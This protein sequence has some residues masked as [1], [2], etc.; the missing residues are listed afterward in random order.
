MT[1]KEIQF[2]ELKELKDELIGYYKKML[3]ASRSKIEIE[4]KLILDEIKSE[5]YSLV[6]GSLENTLKKLNLNA[7]SMSECLSNLIEGAKTQNIQELKSSVNLFGEHVRELHTLLINLSVLLVG[8][9]FQ[10]QL[11]WL[12]S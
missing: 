5:E 10:F 4:G 11:I 9:C 2:L 1:E 7:D 8:F 3:E 12:N 6:S